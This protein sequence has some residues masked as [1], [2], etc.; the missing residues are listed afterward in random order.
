MT[1]M[2]KPI[3]LAIAVLGLLL[4]ALMVH[5]ESEPGA[6][7][8]ALILVGAGGYAVTRVRSRRTRM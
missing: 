8:L 1:G 6:I 2:H 4:M 7:P 5:T 3:F